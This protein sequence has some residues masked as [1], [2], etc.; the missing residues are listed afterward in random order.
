MRFFWDRIS[1]D[2][3][4]QS[5]RGEE[6]FHLLQLDGEQE[7]EAETAPA[8]ADHVYR[9][10]RQDLADSQ[11]REDRLAAEND[12]LRRSLAETQAEVR[13]LETRLAALLARRVQEQ[14]DTTTVDSAVHAAIAEDFRCLVDQDLHHLA[15]INAAAPGCTPTHIPHII[16]ILCRV[17]FGADPITE[18]RVREELVHGSPVPEKRITH[19]C[20]Q[21]RRLRSRAVAT[22]HAYQWSFSFRREIPLDPA[23][24][25]AWSTC[26]PEHIV[27]FLVAPGYLAQGRVYGLQQVY[28]S[29]DG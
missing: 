25:E 24:Q 22:G 12:T 8:F 23:T 5:R 26:D 20:A 27:Q 14:T 3:D 7:Y 4:L 10:L 11:L 1:E 19:V 15:R 21:A 6:P 17:L 29:S 9:L 2:T 13:K 18:Q 28:T 16:A